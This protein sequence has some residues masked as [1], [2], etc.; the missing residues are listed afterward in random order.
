MCDS[1]ASVPWK[2]YL[3][4]NILFNNKGFETLLNPQTKLLNGYFNESSYYL[5]AVKVSPYTN[6]WFD[7]RGQAWNRKDRDST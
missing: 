4:K 1:I 3:L 2:I 5:L 6:N 7:P